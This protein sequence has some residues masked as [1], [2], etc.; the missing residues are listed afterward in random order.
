MDISI[1][2]VS[3]NRKFTKSLVRHADALAALKRLAIG[4][5]TAGLPFDVLQLVFLDRSENYMRSVG[6][7][8]DRLFQ[9]EVAIPDERIVD[10][11]DASIFVKSIAQRLDK[12]IAV[13][14]LPKSI[15]SQL[16]A[17]IEEF[18]HA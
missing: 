7:K 5:D 17:I 11:G 10:F 14:G 12:A 15:E 18:T 1:T 16:S 8:G 6:C 3:R 13:C 9:I 2:S 4:I